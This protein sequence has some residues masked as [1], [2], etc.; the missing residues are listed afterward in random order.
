MVL[1]GRYDP[2]THS[3]KHSCRH[4]Q[5]SFH[6][7]SESRRRFH[8]RKEAFDDHRPFRSFIV[9]YGFKPDPDEV[10][11]DMEVIQAAFHRFDPEAVVGIQL[12]PKNGDFH[13]HI[14]VQS[15]WLDLE[16]W[17][18]GYWCPD[19]KRF[20]SKRGPKKKHCL[21]SV[22]DELLQKLLV[23][24]QARLVQGEFEDQPESWLRYV[25]RCKQG[26]PQDEI[27][28][29]FDKYKLFSGL[30]TRNR[31]PGTLSRAS[32]KAVVLAV[33]VL[34]AVVVSLAFDLGLRQPPHVRG[35]CFVGSLHSASPVG[36]VRQKARG[37]PSR[38]ALL[39][40]DFQRTVFFK[41]RS[42]WGYSFTGSTLPFCLP[43]TAKSLGR[44]GDPRTDG[45]DTQFA[46]LHSQS[47]DCPVSLA[48]SAHFGYA[49]ESQEECRYEDPQ[50]LETLST[51]T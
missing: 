41:P 9:H 4:V 13:L 3:Y 19:T 31:R 43:R 21:G 51:R 22:G 48:A 16:Q 38:I 5:C 28:P 34:V 17:L 23:P 11:E 30:I 8:R 33:A 10:K 6:G 15:A 37:P 29:K 32:I 36:S 45:V 25:M 50:P 26:W 39:W 20:I 35:F 49:G 40:G 14:G 47:L 18:S 24:R 2:I 46:P 27:L 7:L 42:P 44:R 12:H 1:K